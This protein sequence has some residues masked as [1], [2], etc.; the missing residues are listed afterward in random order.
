MTHLLGNAERVVE[1]FETTFV[2]QH[3]AAGCQVATVRSGLGHINWSLGRGA[4]ADGKFIDTPA[5]PEGSRSV[6]TPPQDTVRH[7]P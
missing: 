6:T 3:S 4:I 7:D 2:I 5:S 1:P